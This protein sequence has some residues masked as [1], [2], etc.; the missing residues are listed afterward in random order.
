MSLL[1][2]LMSHMYTCTLCRQVPGKAPSLGSHHPSF[3]G[4][5]LGL[6]VWRGE[7][8]VVL[9]TEEGW[10]CG[11]QGHHTQTCQHSIEYA[12]PSLSM[13]P[14]LSVC[15]HFLG[16]T[17][18]IGG[19]PAPDYV[20]Q[21]DRQDCNQERQGDPLIAFVLSVHCVSIP[22]ETPTWLH[23]KRGN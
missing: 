11:G 20:P 2:S 7:H 8:C 4:Q 1:S 9:R 6:P 21:D 14:K 15:H 17:T 23:L 19:K 18:V 16:I 13:D 12:C 22:R 5:I 10:E 3:Q